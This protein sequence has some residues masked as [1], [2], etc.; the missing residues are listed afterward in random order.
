MNLPSIDSENETE[1]KWAIWLQE[2]I[3]SYHQG[4]LTN[5]EKNKFIS[6]AREFKIELPSSRE[7]FLEECDNFRKYMNNR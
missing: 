3:K 2:N 7:F 1:K 6:L 4:T 5:Y